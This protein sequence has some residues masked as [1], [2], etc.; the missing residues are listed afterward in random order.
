M[1]EMVPTLPSSTRSWA[2][3]S[4]P[5][6]WWGMWQA[7]QALPASASSVSWAVPTTEGNAWPAGNRTQHARRAVTRVVE[8]IGGLF[9]RE[10]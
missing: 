1:A 4:S 2:Q 3:M 8:V 10:M 5:E 9:L 7:L 6:A